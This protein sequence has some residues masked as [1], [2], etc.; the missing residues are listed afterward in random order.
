ML[1]MSDPRF[2]NF[3]K[4]LNDPSKFVRVPS[5]AIF[6]EHLERNEQGKVEHR[7]SKKDLE[8]M[9]RHNNTLASQGDMA[10]IVFGHT[11]PKE[12]Q[13][14]KQ[15]PPR[16]YVRNYHTT[17]D[18]KRKRWLL[19]ADYF[20]RKQDY[21]PAK[22]FPF[23]SIELWP[24]DY[25]IHPVSLLRRTPQRPLGQ[26]TYARGD[27]R[28]AI[29]APFGSPVWMFGRQG[30]PVLRYA[31]QFKGGAHMPRQVKRHAMEGEPMSPEVDMEPG[32]GGDEPSHEE[33]L[34]QFARHCFSH[35]HAKYF[36]KHYAM[37]EGEDAPADDMN[38][39]TDPTAPPD[40]AEE[41]AEPYS[42]ATPS[43]T[44]ASLPGEQDDLPMQNH[45]K[46]GVNQNGKRGK[47]DQY[48][49]MQNEI[50]ALKK[51]NALRSADQVVTQ[52]ESEHYDLDRERE[53]AAFAALDDRGREAR[54]AYIRQ[55]FR[56]APIGPMVPMGPANDPATVLDDPET[57]SRNDQLKVLQYQRTHD[58]CDYDEA[59]AKCFPKRFARNGKAGK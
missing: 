59:L 12:R 46:N 22:T 49:R 32:E 45:R 42:M 9:A 18:E 50:D 28:F 31:M 10:P 25:T 41:P 23:T 2:E 51:E 15:P 17:W 44:N 16:G 24:D 5:V 11:N 4:D 19:K 37:D 1:S 57:M 7:F 36:A 34:E 40:A 8:R 30:R 3:L 43:A 21:N 26:W 20:I 6:D 29:E 14:E 53:V 56:Q 38:G 58:Y 33:K 35:P 39:A 13:E 47:P 55:Y 52:L 48:A 54:A 27:T